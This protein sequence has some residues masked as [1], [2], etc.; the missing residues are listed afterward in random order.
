MLLPACALLLSLSIFSCS[1]K[2]QPQREIPVEN[3]PVIKAAIP[4]VIA[5]NDKVAKK[6]V[7]GRLYYDVDGRRYWKNYDD[8][9]YYLFN[10]SM[11]NNPAFKPH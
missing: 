10:R 6:S 8:G 7:D 1:K 5:V 2:H 3:T 4:R 11:Y 9:K